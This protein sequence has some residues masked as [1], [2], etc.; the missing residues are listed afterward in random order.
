MREIYN[1]VTSFTSTRLH[2]QILFCT[3][4]SGWNRRPFG[5]CSQG[6]RVDLFAA[7]D[8][9][10]FFFLSWKKCSGQDVR[11]RVTLSGWLFTKLQKLSN[12]KESVLI[13][14]GLSCLM[15]Q[16][17]LSKY[18][19][20]RLTVSKGSQSL[21]S[22]HHPSFMRPLFYAM[23]I[24]W[25]KISFFFMHDNEIFFVYFTYLH[26]VHDSFYWRGNNAKKGHWFKHYNYGKKG[27]KVKRGSK[28][29]R[30]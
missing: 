5:W 21:K 14:G 16:N 13:N 23:I 6:D 9:M 27:D 12:L 26:P 10:Q 15:I 17:S 11:D 4:C 29:A 1:H 25:H 22:S 18:Y 2:V 30:A 20:H 8:A 19:Y 28:V 3:L 24:R 7:H